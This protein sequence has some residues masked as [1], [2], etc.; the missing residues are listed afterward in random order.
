MSELIAARR[1]CFA[2]RCN[3][4]V[5][6]AGSILKVMSQGYTKLSARLKGFI[7]ADKAE[8]FIGRLTYCGRDK[9]S[10]SAFRRRK[11]EEG[12]RA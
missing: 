5:N 11:Y 7:S 3:A 6:A 10:K 4:P 12:S 9:R 8:I 2:A 1:P